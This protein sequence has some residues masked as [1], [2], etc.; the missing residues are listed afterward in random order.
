MS[1][2]LKKQALNGVIWSSI[3]RFSMQGIQF[4][5][6]IIIARQL[7]PS[8]YGIIAMLAIFL[9]LAQAFIDSGFSNALIQKQN[10]TDID[11]STVFFFNIGVG[12]IMYGVL[13]L[14]APAISSFYDMPLLNNIIKWVGL[15]LIV[16]S[17]ATVQR[18]KLTIELDF[19][20]QAVISIVSTL[21]GGGVSVW[22][23]YRGYGVWTLVT[24]VLVGNFI[25]TVLLWWSARW[26]PR[27]AFSIDSFKELFGFGSKLLAGG[28]IHIIYKNLY[29]L[30]IGKMFPVSHLGAYNKAYTITQYPSSNLTGVLTRVTYPI[31]CKAQSDNEKLYS[32]FARIIKI[33][34]I[35]IFPLMIGLCAVAKPFVGLLLTDK[36]L[37]CVPYLQIMCI[38]FMWDPIMRLCW[39]IL[40]V[41]HRSDYSLKSEIWKKI[42]AFVLLFAS[43]PFGIKAMCV[44]LIIYSISDI[45]IVTRFTKRIIPQISFCHIMLLI[46]PCL[47]CSVVMGCIV[48]AYTLFI[49]TYILQLFGGVFIGICVYAFLSYFICKDDLIY[50]ISLLRNLVTKKTKNT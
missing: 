17:F 25:T 7:V 40:N 10:R 50:T 37:V 1:E 22:M 29:T 46:S 2:T 44:S 11:Y 32:I 26:I 13:V 12:I 49:S 34:T 8:D 16:T 20:R 30:I 21:L 36:W 45:F 42:V 38:A 5:L 33:S 24:S 48:Y 41:K 3:D 18:A 43:V 39:D 35:I 6:S 4:I 9:A 28:L 15:N 31:E 27:F 19:K 47:V 23:A 14:C